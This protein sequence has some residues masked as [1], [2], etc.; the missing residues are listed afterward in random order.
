MDANII[1][2][3][4]VGAVIG[5]STNWLAI[6]MLFRPYE[7]KKIGNIRIPFTPGVIPR[8]RGRIA[9]S[10]GQAV[11]EKLLTEEVI[12]GEL[13][14]ERVID[15]INDYVIKDLLAKDFS[16][17]QLLEAVVGEDASDVIGKVSQG[18][19]NEIGMYL[20][21]P[22]VR[23]IIEA[24]VKEH[25]MSIVPMEARLNT[26]IGQSAIDDIGVIVDDHMDAI[27][28]YISALAHGEVVKAR[29]AGAIE[30]LVLEKVGALGAMFLDPSGMAD[31]VV[32]YVDGMLGEAE[33]RNGITATVKDAFAAVGEGELKSLVGIQLYQGVIDNVTK[34]I[35]DGL[36]TE[37]NESKL[38]DAVMPMVHGFFE[39]EIHLSDREKMLVE[40]QVAGLYTEFVEKN[41]GTFLETFE[42]SNIVEK[43]INT[44]SVEA[45][46][47]LIFGIVDK[48]LKAI[49][50]LGGLL[51]F[52]I[53]LVYV[54]L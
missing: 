46:E 15:H 48:E 37:L 21:Q 4:L 22:D 24:S 47:E 7:E 40:K 2:K 1:I 34:T 20:N 11:G 6:K 13:L 52:I 8:E 53:G 19:V 50:W 10:L 3:P 9:A 26:W 30:T 42:V 25:V 18:I 12:K 39:K 41:I 54:V 5:Y 49:T 45:I 32:A 29:V 43:E 28:G 14:N 51:G 35:V 31:S 44:F 17:A 36:Y 33:V 27:T 16:L 23:L 38:T